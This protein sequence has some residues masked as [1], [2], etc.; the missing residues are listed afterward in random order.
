MDFDQTALRRQGSIAHG[1]GP[2]DVDF[3]ELTN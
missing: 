3:D 2:D 1:G